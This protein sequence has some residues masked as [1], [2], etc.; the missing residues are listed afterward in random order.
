MQ[1]LDSLA[2]GSLAAKAL[3]SLREYSLQCIA[4]LEAPAAAAAAPSA[5]WP[6]ATA[7]AAS[8]AAGAAA[9][10]AAAATQ[11]MSASDASLAVL[12]GGSDDTGAVLAL[13]R[14]VHAVDR[15]LELLGG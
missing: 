10:G 1:K 15:A 3:R 7:P 11:A 6:A 14:L 9:S 13:Q 5:A 2:G 8:A 12:G 4:T